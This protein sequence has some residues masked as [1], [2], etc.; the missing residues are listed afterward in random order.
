MC[1]TILV[2]G[3]NT[4]VE[5]GKTPSALKRD[6]FYDT[7]DNQSLD[8]IEKLQDIELSYYKSWRTK[9]QCLKEL[10]IGHL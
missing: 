1:K 6:W 5:I 4:A 8:L 2:S 10:P 9:K 3:Y 7:T